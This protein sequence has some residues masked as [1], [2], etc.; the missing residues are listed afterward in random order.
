MVKLPLSISE[1][2][3]SELI[4]VSVGK[5]WFMFGVCMGGVLS[6]LG[7]SFVLVQIYNLW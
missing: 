1:T 5:K 3:V 6:F 4:S 2:K 7:F